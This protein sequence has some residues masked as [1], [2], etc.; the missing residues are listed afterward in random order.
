M[1]VLPAV[2]VLGIGDV[3]EIGL[4]EHGDD[5]ARHPLEV[6]FQ[7][8][9]PHDAA[10][11]VVGAGHEDE[12]GTGPDAREHPLQVGRATLRRHA[13]HVGAHQG[14]RDAIGWVGRRGD[15][16]LVSRG[17]EDERQGPDQAHRAIPSSGPVVYRAS[18]RSPWRVCTHRAQH[19]A[20]L[21]R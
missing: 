1:E 9:P 17:E 13:L 18:L 20:T 6:V 19:T 5:V 7:R 21:V 10:G 12:P 4:V 16:D 3:L 2:G 15:H 11:G 14:A 8:P